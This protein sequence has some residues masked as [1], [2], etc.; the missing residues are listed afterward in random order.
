MYKKL[1]LK[2]LA[3]VLV[4]LIAAAAAVYLSD[5]RKGERSFRAQLVDADTSKITTIVIY[6]KAEK[7]KA[8]E[9]KK[10][11]DGWKVI[12]G[13]NSYQ[14]DEMMVK[15]M[16]TLL[17][18]L[19][20]QRLAATEKSRWAEFDV[21]D[22]A[23][24]RVKLYTGKKLATQLYVGRFSYQPPQ[25]QYP[26]NYGQQGTM[27]TF[28]R[29]ANENSVF[30]VEGFLGMS[31]GRSVNDFRKKVVTRFNEEDV[32]RLSF[33]Y[34]ADSSFALVKEGNRWT[35]N[36]LVCDSASV[37]GYINAL[38]MLHSSYFVDD[39]KPLDDRSD[40]TLNIEGNNFATPIVVKAFESDTTIRYIISSSLNEGAYFSGKDNDLAN[41]IFV[42]KNRFLK[43]QESE[44]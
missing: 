43:Q 14:A 19:K 7:E 34:P 4:I 20:P 40:L 32:S 6:P 9:L 33:T 17:A 30:S 36:G 10:E 13:T 5:S 16:M 31:F 3:I 25:N 2:T 23:A 21:T 1:N 41:K 24:T 29:L 27:S 26:Y 37:A 18:G 11:S 15:N 22:S 38:S 28:V 44:G 12:S 35:I 42:S 8:I 39:Q